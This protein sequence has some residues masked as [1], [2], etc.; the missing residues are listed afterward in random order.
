MSEPAPL[1]TPVHG[2]PVAPAPFSGG[3][4][5]GAAFRI[6]FRQ[7]F[8][9]FAGAALIL[10][11]PALLLDA[12]ALGSENADEI[13]RASVFLWSLTGSVLLA[14]ITRGT[15]DTFDGAPPGLGRILG[16]AGAR[17]LRVFGAGIISGLVALLG[18]V[19]LV[20]PG[21]IACAGLF[22]VGPAAA[23]EPET[24]ARAALGRSWTLTQGH[25]WGTLGVFLLFRAIALGATL[26][27]AG[28]ADLLA[29]GSAAVL[30]SI[31]GSALAALAL[32][33]EATAT[34]VAYHRLRA[35]KEGVAPPT[36]AA[37]FE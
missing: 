5:I 30:A 13:Y 18:L 1:R 24:G 4:V 17:G 2:A 3:E 7:R 31:A 29:D 14:G 37:V 20:V 25:R 36:L 32:A 6:F 27:G 34:A 19:L 28:A 23:A 10:Y 21:L 8:A 33:L 9:L 16:T 35:E 22:V 11:A 26:A 12:A 15:L